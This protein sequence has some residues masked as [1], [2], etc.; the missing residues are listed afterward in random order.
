MQLPSPKKECDESALSQM[1]PTCSDIPNLTSEAIVVGSSVIVSVTKN[2]AK[3]D[4]RKGEVVA[5][6]TNDYKIQLDDG[7]IKKFPHKNVKIMKK[8]EVSN[9]SNDTD[10]NEVAKQLFG[11]L[12]DVK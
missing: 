4:Q 2:R 5:V 7:E 1:P 12:S 10:P 9:G 6:L 11:D 8:S 3:Y